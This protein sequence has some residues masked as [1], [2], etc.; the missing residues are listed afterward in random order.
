MNDMAFYEI[1]LSERD[2]VLIITALHVAEIASVGFGFETAK[3]FNILFYK[4]GQIKKM[5][6]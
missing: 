6:N 5:E 1:E 4:F 3:E 2:I